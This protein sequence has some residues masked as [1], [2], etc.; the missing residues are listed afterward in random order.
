[1]RIERPSP[2]VRIT[3][4]AFFGSL[5]M[6]HPLL[7]QSSFHGIGFLSRD[8]FPYSIATAVSADGS[9]IVGTSTNNAFNGEAYRWTIAD[10]M[11]GLG[12]LPGS[13]F[14]S[15]ACAVSSDGSIVAGEG[16]PGELGVYE[17]TRWSA[18]DGM[19]GLGVAGGQSQAF[20]IS[21]DGS[22]IVGWCC[23]FHAFRWT[24]ATGMIG[25]DGDDSFSSYATACSRDGRVIVGITNYISPNTSFAF[26]WT[27]QAGIVRLGL[28]PGW[29]ISSANA[30]SADGTTIVGV[31]APPGGIPPMAFR[32]TADEGLQ[33]LGG[34]AGGIGGSSAK[35][36]SDDGSIIAGSSYS[37][38]GWEPFVWT[39]A[40]GMRSLRLLLLSE[41]VDNLSGWQLNDLRGISADG[42]TFV[43]SGVD[44]CGQSEGWIARLDGPAV[45]TPRCFADWNHSGC[46]N[47]QDFFDFLSSFFAGAADFNSDGITN[48]Q[49]F[50]DFLTAFFAG[51]N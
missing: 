30:V 22:V 33:A 6:T 13:V 45:P 4:V 37:S 25:F 18:G 47:S 46:L 12:D 26:R 43:G 44:P 2:S 27:E 49:D 41:N 9:V 21:G 23:G 7:A 42:K 5:L 51:C 50:F 11:V 17:A 29:A 3:A 35:A 40:D 32:W 14:N 28:L 19:V 31:G 10:G 16:T 34:L 24:A 8:R 38:V 48:S 39:A 20:G 15:N 36:V 1:M